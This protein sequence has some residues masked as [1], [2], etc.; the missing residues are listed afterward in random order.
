MLADGG[1]PAMPV[2]PVGLVRWVLGRQRGRVV[3]GA[4]A[5]I[6]WMGSI[7][8]LPVALGGA[9][10]GAVDG[11]SGSDVARWC[12]VLAA[13]VV[14]EAVAGVVRH[15]TAVLLYIRTR[16][17]VERLLTRRVLDP[18][19]GVDGEAGSLLSRAQTDAQAIGG[20]SDLMCRGSGAVVTFLAVGIGMLLASP[21][22]GLVVL[23]GLPPCLLVLA[24]LWRPYDRRATEQQARMA[25]ATS[26][27]A[28]SLA[29]LRVVKGLGGEPA[30]RG[31]FA[32]STAGVQASAV[33]LAR[34]GSAWTALS[35][36]IPGVF[37]AVVLWVGGRQVVDGALAPGELVTF[38][39]LAVFLAIPL[40]TFA[41]VG[42]VWASGIAGARRVADVLNTAP[43]VDDDGAEG[44]PPVGGVV[45]D[46][47]SHNRLDRFD[48]AVGDDEMV[49]VACTDSAAATALAD[50]LARRVDPRR[51]VVAVG[52]VDVRS[53]PLHVL[54]AHAAVDDGH[55]PWLADGT[56]GDNV[57]LGAPGVTDDRLVDALV[58]AAADELAARP[59]GV[60]EQVGEG[61]SSLSGGQRQR[62]AMARAVA[63]DAA[64]LVLDDPTSALDTVTEARFAER[65]A[66]A[67]AGRATVI[68]TVSPTVLAACDRVAFV[69]DGRVAATASHAELLETTPAYRNLVAPEVDV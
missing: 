14:A 67:R 34:L 28:D 69:A 21:T 22:L 2:T 18:R 33:S 37:L 55:H 49:G 9:I 16:W 15:R 3:V 10:D 13:I 8:L 58:V 31:W 60:R 29:G 47:V 36:V 50:L 57:A 30:V 40:S 65:L 26:V 41:E 19:G 51:G 11:G 48:L 64:V 35:G 62:V 54:R 44:R 25:D 32:S 24:P 23:V 59:A 52:G 6:A 63:A 39:G 53:I 56:L 12:T 61:G 4:V 7:A 45:F 17:L 20:I 42:D 66:A 1:G 43:A 46:G 5:G 38:T 27:A 68:L